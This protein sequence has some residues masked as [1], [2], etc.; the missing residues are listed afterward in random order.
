MNQQRAPGEIDVGPLHGD[1]LADAPR[2]AAVMPEQLRDP[3]LP[4][5][6][7]QVAL[8]AR[9]PGDIPRL[10]GDLYDDIET[11]SRADLHPWRPTPPD[12]TLSPYAVRARQRTPPYLRRHDHRKRVGR[13]GAAVGNRRSQ[14]DGSPRSRFRP[15]FRGRGLAVE[16]AHLLCSTDAGPTASSTRRSA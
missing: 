4:L 11:R 8:R 16:I 1:K 13:R 10:Q 6:G 5:K 7:V 3:G 12:P 9:H 2:F 15:A 14:P